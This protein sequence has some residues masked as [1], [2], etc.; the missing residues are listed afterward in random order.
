[1]YAR[2]YEPVGL[3]GLGEETS[4]LQ[5][6]G[7]GLSNLLTAGAITYTNI[8]NLKNQASAREDQIKYMDAQAR[9]NI[10]MAQKYGMMSELTK[11]Q[12]LVPIVLGVGAIGAAIF[13]FKKR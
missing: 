13:Y 11:A 8:L 10:T 2:K 7:S 4:L 5:S 9:A 12:N 3:H 1:M 6:V